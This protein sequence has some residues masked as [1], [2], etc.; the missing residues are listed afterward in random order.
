MLTVLLEARL[1][2][3]GN[4]AI[5]RSNRHAEVARPL[6]QPRVKHIQIVDFAEH[7]LQPTQAAARSRRSRWQQQFDRVAEAFQLNA[8][9][10]PRFGRVAA[11]GT[12]MQSAQRQVVI[13]REAL[14]NRTVGWDEAG[15]LAER[16]R[17]S[18]PAMLVE[19]SKGTTH[20]RAD[21]RL[22]TP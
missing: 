8:Q 20:A 1:P 11:H 21:V 17:K 12:L 16:A 3:D 5:E 22:L 15:A 2:L 19:L 6:T 7:R 9:R 4:D 18:L 10:M 13:E 14:G